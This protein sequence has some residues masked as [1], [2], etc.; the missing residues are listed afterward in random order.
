MQCIFDGIYVNATMISAQ[1]IECI[2]PPHKVGKIEV[3]VTYLGD[4]GK[5][6]SEPLYFT[7]VERP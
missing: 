5:S 3:K 4:K 1:E 2:T 6:I 7:Y